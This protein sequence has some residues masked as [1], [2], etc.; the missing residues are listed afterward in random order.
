MMLPVP[1]CG[2]EFGVWGLG[3]GVWGLGFGV[4]GLG[5]QF[6]HLPHPNDAVST[7]GYERFP[8]RCK[9][10]SFLCN[11]LVVQVLQLLGQ[12]AREE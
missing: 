2:A 4:W 7:C 3:F 12:Y 5:F 11:T 1:T 9:C 10:Y 6:L 8:L